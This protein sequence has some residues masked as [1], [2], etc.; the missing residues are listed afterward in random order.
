MLT[1]GSGRSANIREVM[2][3]KEKIIE[4]ERLRGFKERPFQMKNDEEMHRLKHSILFLLYI[5]N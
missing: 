2:E 3:E 4:I 5:D 1:D